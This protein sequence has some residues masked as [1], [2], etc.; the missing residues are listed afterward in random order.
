MTTWDQ[1]HIVANSIDGVNGSNPQAYTLQYLEGDG[2]LIMVIKEIDR[3]VKKGGFIVIRNFL[4][5]TQHLEKVV[6]K[7]VRWKLVKKV[8]P[9]V[10]KGEF[11]AKGWKGKDGL[12]DP[13]L[14]TLGT[15]RTWVWT[16]E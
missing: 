1:A 13:S 10:W 6:A 9:D 12:V 15:G 2:Q 11:V 16:K 3:L 7:E 5:G 8:E 4:A 14:H